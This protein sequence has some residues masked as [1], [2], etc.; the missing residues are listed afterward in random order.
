M[1]ISAEVSKCAT[2]VEAQTGKKFSEGVLRII[3]GTHQLGMRLEELGR[4]H[5]A[6]CYQ[7][8]RESEMRKLTREIRDLE[9]EREINQYLFECYMVGYNAGKGN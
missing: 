5:A 3:E 2:R 7:P 1:N 4:K 9:T 8:I 6:E